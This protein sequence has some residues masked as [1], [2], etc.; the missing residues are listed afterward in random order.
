MGKCKCGSLYYGDYCENKGGSSGAFSLL[1]FIFVIALVA[2]G[3][4]LLYARHNLDK[5]QRA[6]AATGDKEGGSMER[7]VR[8]SSYRRGGLLNES[9]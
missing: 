5:E 7:G 3:V 9:Q 2:A 8:S 4:G 6:A 1:I